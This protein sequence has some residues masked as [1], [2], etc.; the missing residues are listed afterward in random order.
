VGDAEKTEFASF[1][2]YSGGRP[3]SPWRVSRN[4][5]KVSQGRKEMPNRNEIEFLKRGAPEEALQLK[6][7]RVLRAY[8]EQSGHAQPRAAT[9]PPPSPSP[10][11]Y[12]ATA[13]SREARS[14]REDWGLPGHEELGEYVVDRLLD[15]LLDVLLRDNVLDRV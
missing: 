2:R 14:L 6:K 4:R 15:D 10:G 12:A 11:G 13:S 8:H 1:E 7:L 9:S 5:Q 3:R